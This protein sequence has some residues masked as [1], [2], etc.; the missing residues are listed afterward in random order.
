MKV[1]QRGRIAPF[2][3]MDV[4][5][6]ANERAAEGDDVIHLE[7]GQ[8]ATRAPDAVLEA[9]RH[10]LAR[11]RL[12][13]T[14][15]LGLMDLRRRIA[16][17]YADI[18]RVEVD[19]ARVVVTTGSSAGFVLA[20]LS[21]FDVGDRVAIACPGYP[22]YRNILRTFGI[23]PVEIFVGPETNF[24][25]TADGLDRIEGRIDG[26]VIA[27]PS[28][29]TGTM[30]HLADLEAIIGCCRERRIRLVADEIYHG[31]TYD[32]PAT[33]A[34]RFDADALVVNSF[35]KYFSMTGW[36]LGWM[37]LPEDLLRSVECL[38]QNMFIAPPT[39]SQF[40]AVHV[41]DCLDELNANV[42][43]Y[44]RNRALLLDQLP[45]AGFD[46]LASA[47][48]AFYIYADVA[49]L[50]NDSEDF[51]RRM[52]RE[53]GVATTPGIDFDPHRGNRY[54]R[55]CFAGGEEDMMLAAERLKDWP[56]T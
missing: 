13:Y 25:P 47:D 28:N 38:S 14:N 9:A 7:V 8:P 55:F 33:T 54:V 27:S 6:A 56:G 4:L 42:A 17:Y 19:P 23:E 5:K 31:I 36:R 48:G 53:T 10:A 1:S 30:I 49:H 24:Q 3:V 15:A 18:H 12:G 46:R 22:A 26:L 2:I 16:G 44:A 21:A 32:E 11:E 51:C 45:Q 41:F 20:F 29:P 52:L 43:R 34:L 37:V 40:A 50:T 39:L 35:S